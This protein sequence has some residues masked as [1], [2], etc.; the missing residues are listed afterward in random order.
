MPMSGPPASGSAT[1][2]AI[3][4]VAVSTP[5]T[6]IHTATTSTT[7]FDEVYLWAVNVTAAPHTITVEF[8]GVS[9]PG[10]HLVHNYTIPPNSPLIPLGTGQRLRGSVVVR[11]YLDV[12]LAI[13]VFCNVNRS[14]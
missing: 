2:V 12:T 1:G 9:D 14:S 5:G 6:L 7:G 4:I 10:S 11:A 8:G 13:N 3:P